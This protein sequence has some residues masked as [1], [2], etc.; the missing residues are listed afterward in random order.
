MLA[1]ALEPWEDAL[2]QRGLITWHVPAAQFVKGALCAVRGIGS[3]GELVNASLGGALDAEVHLPCPR[4]PAVGKG[5]QERIWSVAQVSKTMQ[6]LLQ[7]EDEGG[8]QPWLEPAEASRLPRWLVVWIHS[9][10]WLA[11]RTMSKPPLAA[12]SR[13]ATRVCAALAVAWNPRN[14]KEKPKAD[15]R[16]HKSFAVRQFLGP[17]FRSWR[18]GKSAGLSDDLTKPRTGVMLEASWRAEERVTM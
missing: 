12:S 9:L 5:V 7:H 13:M 17:S 10:S 8:L 6:S 14:L 3:Q 16:C 4:A 15:C 18:D 2:Y 11:R 1:Q